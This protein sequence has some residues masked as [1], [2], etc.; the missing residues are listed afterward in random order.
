LAAELPTDIGTSYH[1]A[2]RD[3]ANYCDLPRTRE[4]VLVVP[5]SSAVRNALGVGAE[6][7]ERHGGYWSPAT[8]LAAGM[9]FLSGTLF[10]RSLRVN[11]LAL[12]NLG[13]VGFLALEYTQLWSSSIPP[14]WP[15]IHTP[16]PPQTLSGSITALARKSA[17]AHSVSFLRVTDFLQALAHTS[18]D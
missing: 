4:L 13:G 18:T 7:W 11:T 8:V 6:E 2:R 15:P 5:P 3:S 17:K 9:R 10:R 14:Q 12:T 1:Q 16:R